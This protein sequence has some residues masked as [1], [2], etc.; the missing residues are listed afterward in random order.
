ML[1]RLTPNQCEFLIRP[2]D[3]TGDPRAIEALIVDSPSP[4][5]YRGLLRS[6]GETEKC[7]GDELPVT[8]PEC[9]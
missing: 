2:V 3:Q 4:T 6:P 8:R 1:A 7:I 5:R 9:G